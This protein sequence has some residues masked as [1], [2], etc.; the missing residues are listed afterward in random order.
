MLKENRG[1]I[2]NLSGIVEF[3]ATQLDLFRDVSVKT[4]YALPSVAGSFE[5]KQFEELEHDLFARGL[6]VGL[7]HF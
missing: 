5:H 3:Q 2:T 4:S 7:D 6:G 1:C